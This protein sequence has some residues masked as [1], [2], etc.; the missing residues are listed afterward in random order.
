MNVLV[1]LLCLGG[2]IAAVLLVNARSYIG[3]RNGLTR[4]KNLVNDQL[5]PNELSTSVQGLPGIFVGSSQ[6]ERAGRGALTGVKDA[7]A[8]GLLQDYDIDAA[9]RRVHTAGTQRAAFARALAGI[10]II[11]GLLVTLFNLRVS[12]SNLES[13]FENMRTKTSVAVP[14]LGAPPVTNDDSLNTDAL[15]NAMAGIASSATLAFGWSAAFIS[16]ACGLLLGSF[17]WTL[18]ITPNYSRFD[19]TVHTLYLRLLPKHDDQ[20]QLFGNLAQAVQS[21]EKLSETFE[22]TNISLKQI[23]GF[24]ERFEAAAHEIAEAVAKVPAGMRESVADMSGSLAREIAQELA[25]YIEHIKGILAIYGDQQVLLTTIVKAMSN[26]EDDWHRSSEAL[27]DLG[28]I[29]ESITG[30]QAAIGLYTAD[31]AK[32]NT[33]VSELD[34]KVQALPI[35]DL[36]SAAHDMRALADNLAPLVGSVQDVTGR[37]KELVAGI[38]TESQRE[39]RDYIL[40]SLTEM[41]IKM[42]TAL[43]GGLQTLSDEQKTTLTNLTANAQFVATAIAGLG[44][45]KT[46]LDLAAQLQR[47]TD[48]LARVPKLPG[49]LI[50]ASA[51]RSVR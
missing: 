30:L 17:G 23:G 5:T 12:V 28:K 49:F 26:M 2:A 18:L 19:E 37:M 25:H 47:L 51:N 3:F 7:H 27:A 34:Q 35:Q 29:P 13:V 41:N 42:T 20:A 32:L 9:I 44:G 31:T 39:A 36:S 43:Q 21:L 1:C 48:E 46:L 14:P 24:G 33:S 45:G 8:Q 11:L 22:Q 40:A 6:M 50:R 10:V 16:I 4:L 38:V 15:Q